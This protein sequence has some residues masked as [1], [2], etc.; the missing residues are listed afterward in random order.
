MIHLRPGK[1]ME[2][3]GDDI[4]QTVLPMTLALDVSDLVR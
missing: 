1:S 2:V 3:D 4:Y